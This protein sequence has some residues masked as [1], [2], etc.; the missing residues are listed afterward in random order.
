MASETP[1]GGANRH[2][3]VVLCHSEQNFPRV[4][5]V[6]LPAAAAFNLTSYT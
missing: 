4:S 1:T 5:Q 6:P 2:S 3:N